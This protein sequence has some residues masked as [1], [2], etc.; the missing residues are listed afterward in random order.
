MLKAHRP[1]SSKE[2]EGKSSK[3]GILPT[4]KIL[5]NVWV[6]VA[7]SNKQKLQ[8]SAATLVK[9]SVHIAPMSVESEQEIT[10]VCIYNLP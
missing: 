9:L 2:R 3:R 6:G 1:N 4:K 5:C 8:H 7:L 10:C